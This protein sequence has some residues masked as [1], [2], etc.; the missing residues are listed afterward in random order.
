[1]KSLTKKRLYTAQVSGTKESV[2]DIMDIEKGDI[3]VRQESA[4]NYPNSFQKNIK[5]GKTVALTNFENPFASLGKVYKE[6]IKY[7]R[8]DGVDLTGTLY[9]PAGYD[10]NSKKEKLK[11]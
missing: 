5:T 11:S 7:K 10:R 2:I 4:T 1:M 9:L 8:N 3:L 6:V